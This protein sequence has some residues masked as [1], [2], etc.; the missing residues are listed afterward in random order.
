MSYIG[1]GLKSAQ[2]K[3]EWGVFNHQTIANS[4]MPS[5]AEMENAQ[6]LANA[7]SYLLTLPAYGFQMASSRGK[8]AKAFYENW[9]F[10]NKN[11]TLLD[12]IQMS[13][14][15]AKA[16]NDLLEKNDKS[17]YFKP[18]FNGR[19][20]QILSARELSNHLPLMSHK[21]NDLGYEQ[22]SELKGNEVDTTEYIIKRKKKVREL[23]LNLEQMVLIYNKVCRYVIKMDEL[24]VRGSSAMYLSSEYGRII[25]R[26]FADSL[27]Y[28][29]H[30]SPIYSNDVSFNGYGDE[31]KEAFQ[32]A[33][34][35]ESIKVALE[36]NEIEYIHSVE[37]NRDTNAGKRTYQKDNIVI[38]DVDKELHTRLL[39]I[40]IEEALFPFLVSVENIPAEINEDKA[41]AMA[42]EYL[43]KTKAIGYDVSMLGDFNSLINTNDTLFDIIVSTVLEMIKVRQLGELAVAQAK[44]ISYY[45]TLDLKRRD[46]IVKEVFD[47]LKQLA[48]SKDEDTIYM[49]FDPTSTV[50]FEANELLD[51][52][53]FYQDKKSDFLKPIAQL[54]S[55][56]REIMRDLFS[57]QAEGDARPVHHIE[58]D[59]WL[60]VSNPVLLPNGQMGLKFNL[61]LNEIEN[62]NRAVVIKENEVIANVLSKHKGLKFSTG[63]KN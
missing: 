41:F 32:F 25:H 5:K 34:T 14:T 57:K 20:L 38:L 24:N 61:G 1:S 16:I 15:Y 11:A 55:N 53:F 28:G 49:K 42:L 54:N 58:S 39:D 6:A 4:Y 21:R 3:R 59:Q 13:L 37:F 56:I 26:T 36:R 43:D 62:H 31:I 23:K 44:F 33:G 27:L 51:D 40:S 18:Y 30:Y 52:L 7:A 10:K 17:S 50:F 9:L 63:P 35:C 8:A 45:L 47:L 19:L 2:E 48:E 22:V 12:N 60:P 46:Y 29:L